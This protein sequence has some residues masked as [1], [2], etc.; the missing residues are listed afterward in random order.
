MSRVKAVVDVIV[1]V[2]VEIDSTKRLSPAVGKRPARDGEN[3]HFT[4]DQIRDWIADE[5]SLYI[6]DYEADSEHGYLR[7]KPLEQSISADDVALHSA[8]ITAL[9]GETLLPFPEDKASRIKRALKKGQ[10]AERIRALAEKYSTTPFSVINDMDDL[11]FREL[12]R[13]RMENRGKEIDPLHYMRNDELTLYN[14]DEPWPDEPENLPVKEW[15][16]LTGNKMPEEDMEGIIG[17]GFGGYW[18]AICPKC[19]QDTMHV[20]RPGKVQCANCE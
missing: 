1:T 4:Q 9:E 6:V 5:F 11:A 17:D 19:G 13:L 18:S 15:F 10:F 2:E 3:E 8:L 16:E 14:D 7:V 12:E 20:V